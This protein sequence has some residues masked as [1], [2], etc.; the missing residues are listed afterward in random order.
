MIRTATPADLPSL[1]G[2]LARA[3]DSPYDL[4]VVTAEKCFDAGIAGAPTTRVFEH[5]GRPA[6]V[7]VTCGKWIRILGVDPAMRRQRIGSALAEDAEALGGRVVAAEPGN[8]FTP[9]VV[10]S[11]EG[12]LAF[13]RSRGYAETQR[14]WNLEV[15]LGGRLESGGTRALHADRGR[16]LDFIEREFGRIWRFEASRAFDRD[17]P[18]IF[19]EEQDGSIAGFAAHDVNNR[20]LGFFG[21][22]GVAKS[23]RGQGI[24]GRLLQASLADLHR[25]GYARAVIPWT[26]AVDFYRKSSG[27]EPAHRFVAF[28]RSRP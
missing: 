3:N 8:Y 18:T 21:P 14:T 4:A 19:I 15:D 26:D 24:G 11:D 2:L 17:Q 9:G 28:A 16:V 6:G 7:A 20:G 22:T 27:A 23:M 13:W 12:S 1:R 10:L 25:L 5:E